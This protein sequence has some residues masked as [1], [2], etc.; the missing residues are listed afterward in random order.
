MDIIL[1]Q[2]ELLN[3][4]NGGGD[5]VKYELLLD[6]IAEESEI[7]QSQRAESIQIIEKNTIEIN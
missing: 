7:K 4:K 2:E 6:R 1:L 3:C 5:K